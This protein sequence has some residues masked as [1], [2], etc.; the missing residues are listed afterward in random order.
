MIMFKLQKFDEL[1]G[2]QNSRSPL[3]SQYTRSPLCQS[4]WK[5]ER[6]FLNG[7]SSFIE[8]LMGG[9]GNT[10]VKSTR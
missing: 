10:L 5:N 7:M 6:D 3:K 1:F 2:K 8:Q 4:N 9:S